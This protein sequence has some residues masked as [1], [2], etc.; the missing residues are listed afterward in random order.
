MC[1]T[2]TLCVFSKKFCKNFFQNFSNIFFKDFCQNFFPKLRHTASAMVSLVPGLGS[3]KF[4]TQVVY[5]SLASLGL[6]AANSRLHASFTF[7]VRNP[8]LVRC[9]QNFFQKFFPKFV[10]YFFQKFLPIFF[11]ELRH[12]A[13][14]MVS[15]VPGL[16][17]RK[18]A[19]QVVYLS[20]ASLGL[21]AANSRLHASFTFYVRNPNL[22]RFF[23][24]FFQKFFP[25]IFQYFFQ[26]FLPKFLPKLEHTA[27]T[28]VSLVPGLGSRKFATQVVYLSLASLGLVAAN[29]RL[30]ASF[31]FYVRNP[32]LVR[33][34]QKFLQKFFPKLRH[35]ASAMVSLVPGLGSRKFA[36]QVVCLS[37][38]SLGLVAANSRLHASFTFYVRNPN[39]VRCFQNFFQKF[40]PKFVQ[41][42]FQKFLPKFFPELRHTASTMV[43]LVPGLGSR[44]FAT[45]VVYLS[46]A[47]LGLVAANSRLHASFTF[48]VRNPNLVRFFQKFFQKFFPKIFQNFFQKFLPKFLPKFGH[49]ASTMVS[50][51]PGLGS[52]KFATQVPYLSLASFGLVAA[53]SRLH[54][55]F[56][57]YVRN[58]NLVRFFQ[59]F[60]QKF[61]PK[62]FQYFFQ[63]FLPIFF[64]KLRH[65]AS[66][67]VSLVAGLGSR[68]F[69]TQ[70]VYLS[71]AS[72]G[73]VAANSRLHAS[74]TFYVRNP[75]LVRFFKNF[76]QKFFP[77]FVQY[78]FQKFLPKIFP[79]LRHTASTMV[80][81]VPG[82]G[83]RKFATQV[84]YLSLASLGLVAANSR[85]HASFTFYVHNPN[86][87][88]FFQKNFYKFFPKF[89]QYFFQKFLPKLFPKLRHTASTMVSLVPGL[90]S[91]KFA[92]QVVYL[93][94]ASLGLVAANSRLHASFTFYVRNPN[95]VRFF[96]NFFQNFFPKFSQYFFQTF[97][98]KFFPKLRHT[99][100]AM[101]SLVPG[102]GSRKFATQ[103]VYLSLASLGLVAANSRLHASFTFYVRNPN[104]VRFFQKIFQKFF[105]KFFQ[106]F[107]Q[108][109]LLKFFPKLRHRASTMVS[110]VP[111][112]GS[113][114]FATQVVYL[115]LAS[116]GLLAANSRL[117]ASFTFYVRNPNLVQSHRALSDSFLDPLLLLKTTASLLLVCF[118]QRKRKQ[119]STPLRDPCTASADTNSDLVS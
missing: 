72:L 20:L 48:Y 115:S 3:R 93:S 19:T 69:A 117:H 86:L 46:L 100:S 62:I 60:F 71:L 10:Q 11:P 113:R 98:P 65:T 104:L 12:T 107:F 106:Y 50:L 103:V 5:L 47:S 36:T 79:K 33:F 41:Y 97:L 9:F 22:V 84:V 21:V 64:P 17:S 35:T 14:T 2:L 4:A 38:A 52:R 119:R 108:K 88:R 85:L 74:F 26:K 83:S 61:F 23:Q 67:M 116:L 40:F 42:F 70:V 18:F 58:P 45:Q 53:N 110:L 7:Y 55:S 78:F 30:H 29:S 105:P 114:K 90:G 1:V 94:L 109:F 49:T 99:A 80:S 68:K 15:L 89:V 54:A 13:S 73:L 96:Q 16:G 28:M 95:L 6:V 59:N 66:T 31:T 111:G 56:T 87:V 32:N 118:A 102:L 57:F 44:K 8:N 37:L 43:S 24:N 112:L 27:S 75:N 81:L 76:F 77:K 63:K 51:V 25:K 92:T 101:V 82:L 39:L 91:R 34:F